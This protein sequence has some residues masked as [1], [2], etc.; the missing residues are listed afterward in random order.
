[1]NVKIKD[2]AILSGGKTK[3]VCYGHGWYDD[4]FQLIDEDI[5]KFAE[6]IIKECI[7]VGHVSDRPIFEKTCEYADLEYLPESIYRAL[8]QA[9]TDTLDMDDIVAGEFE[10]VINWKARGL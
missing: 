7:G 2:L 5:Q 3:N 9:A 1:M 10:V 8:H 6:L 4:E